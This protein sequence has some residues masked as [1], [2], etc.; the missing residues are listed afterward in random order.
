MR[1][2]GFM[3]GQDDRNRKGDGLAGAFTSAL[4]LLGA[5]VRVL[6]G[7]ALFDFALN[8]SSSQ[9]IMARL[10]AGAA[11]GIDSFAPTGDPFRDEARSWFEASKQSVELPARDGGVLFGWLLPADPVWASPDRHALWSDFG[12]GRRYGIFCHG[13]TGKPSDLCVEAYLAHK[14]GINV[15]LPAARGHERNAD[16]YV[17]MGWLDSWDLL[18]WTGLIVTCDPDAKIALYG[19]SMGGAEVMMASGLDLPGNVRCIIEDCGYTS[20][21]DEFSVQIGM[22]LHLPPIPFLSAASAVCK[23]RAGYGFKEASS[24]NRLRS[25]RVPML[26]I[27][28]TAD[29]F[30]P[31][32]ML[33]KVFDACASPEK[34]RLSVEG[35]GHGMASATNPD[36]YWGRVSAF[37]GRHLA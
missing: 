8:P 3:A 21:W 16:R 9:S 12:R 28:G 1:N 20:V 4:S 18:G 10:G 6:S 7:S 22:Q 13:Y 5:G 24:V 26:F 35:A 17:G 11:G 34:E 29:T 36:A 25:A 27:H 19:V 2:G 33:D 32:E 15:L 14:A 37:L 31:Y 23:R 30:V